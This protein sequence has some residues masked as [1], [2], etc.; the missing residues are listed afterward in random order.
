MRPFL[1]LLVALLVAGCSAEAAGPEPSDLQIGPF[2]EV[3]GTPFL[4]AEL[5]PARA[6]GRESYSSGGGHPVDVLTY[7]SGAREGRWLFGGTGQIVLREHAVADSGRVRAFVYVLVA[8]D[9]DGDGRLDGDDA[10]SVVVSDPG[11]RRTLA[12]APQVDR[13]REPIRLADGALLLLYDVAGSVRGMEID[14][15]ALRVSARVS[16]PPPPGTPSD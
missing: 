5:A 1:A 14:P 8:E 11:G 12:V 7:D 6:S 10:Q 3:A 13:V 15:S 2:S 16:M 9:T 4:R